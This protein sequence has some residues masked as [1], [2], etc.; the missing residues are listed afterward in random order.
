MVKDICSHAAQPGDLVGNLAVMREHLTDM[1]AAL[2]MS[3]EFPCGSKEGFVPFEE[4]K[5]F[6]FQ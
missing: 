4:R 1:H 3:T 5:A 6:A 2:A